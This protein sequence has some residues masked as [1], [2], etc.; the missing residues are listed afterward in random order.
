MEQMSAQIKTQ[1]EESLEEG[2]RMWEAF[3]CPH[4]EIT[5]DFRVA[6]TAAAACRQEAFRADYAAACQCFYLF[7]RLH[8]LVEDSP[9]TATLLGDY[10][11][12]RFS[13]HLIPIDSPRLIDR[14]SEYLKTDTRKEA[15]GAE[16]FDLTQYLA[17]ITEAAKEIG[18]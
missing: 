15:A 1:L 16:A 10:F 14:F 6:E 5:K 18:S 7:R 12:S 13:V 17:F 8:R 3:G 11:F 2:C 4:P 9:Q